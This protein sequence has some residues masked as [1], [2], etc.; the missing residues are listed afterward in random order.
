MP[1]PA[2][3]KPAL[4]PSQRLAQAKALDTEILALHRKRNEDQARIVARLARLQESRG[5]RSLGFPSVQAYA[6]KRLA[7]GA[8][9]AKA[10]LTLHG[11]LPERPLVRKAWESGELDWTKAVLVAR[12]CEKEPQREAY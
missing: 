7:W 4:V 11:R 3:R 5:F 1:K 9:K 8:G 2:A 12:V 6:A 10:M